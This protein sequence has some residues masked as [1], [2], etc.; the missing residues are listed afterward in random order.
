MS[1][2]SRRTS[3]NRLPV[4]HGYDL[5]ELA[6]RTEIVWIAGIERQAGCAGCGCKEKINRTRPP[7][8]AS[9][10]YHRGINPTVSACRL[11]VE[12]QGIECGFRALE[13]VLAAR[14]LFGIGCG[15]R[16]GGKLGHRDSAHGNLDRKQRRLDM[17]KIDD[18]RGVEEPASGPLVRPCSP[19]YTW[20]LFGTTRC[21]RLPDV[22]EVDANFEQQVQ[23]TKTP[24]PSVVRHRAMSLTRAWRNPKNRQS[25]P[26]RRVILERRDGSGGW[27]GRR[28]AYSTGNCLQTRNVD[29]VGKSRPKPPRSR[30]K[31]FRSLDKPNCGRPKVLRERDK[32]GIDRP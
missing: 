4:L 23:V 2:R 9:R 29:K 25:N 20:H 32:I 16:T 28:P 22:S 3:P 21:R 13:P 14:P 7:R 11:S 18:H 15:V 1:L 6:D 17:F 8:L 5:D 24:G 12:G 10:G 31:L 27:S 26:S 30:D 19:W